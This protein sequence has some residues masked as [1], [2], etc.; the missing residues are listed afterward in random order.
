M[1][2]KSTAEPKPGRPRGA[3]NHQADTVAVEPSRCRRCGSTERGPYFNR[4]EREYP[5]GVDPEG[6]LATH[7]VWRRCVC[8]KCGQ[9]RDDRTFENRPKKKRPAKKRPTKKRP[10]KKRQR[11]KE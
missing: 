3:K 8:K 4:R 5:A 7:V 1:P 6:R 9:V 10:T 11:Q 2:K